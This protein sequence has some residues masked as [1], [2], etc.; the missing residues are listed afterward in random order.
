MSQSNNN[1][2]VTENKNEPTI[3]DVIAILG[4]FPVK[5]DF[6]EFKQ[7]L[8]SWNEENKR[9][10]QEVEKQ[11]GSLTATSIDNTDR[12]SEL[13][14]T[15]QVLQQ[16]KLRNNV[17]ISG[18]PPDKD[19]NAMHAVHKI[20][21]TLNVDVS[22]DKFT[23]FPSANN[24]LIIV[25][26][27]H[28]TTKQQ[29]INKIRVKKSLIVEEVFGPTA[30]SNSQ[31]YIND[32]LTK[33][34]SELFLMTRTAKKENKLA[35]ASSIGGKIRVRKSPD[36][37]PVT[38]TN[39]TQ[40]IELIEMDASG[41]AQQFNNDGSSSSQSNHDS[42]RKEKEKAGEKK[43][44]RPKSNSTGPRSLS[45]GGSSTGQ[46]KKPRTRKPKDKVE[47]ASQPSAES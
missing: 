3:A 21:N 1:N 34:F 4:N 24:K 38:I 7:A 18:V 2:A 19:L 30:K 46:S 36:S 39:K 11:V 42:R 23:A 43:R 13:E 8:V 5:S 32:H 9:K 29:L 27:Q 10:I 44:G 15:I 6:M 22:S 31:I 20:A 37:Y 45:Q 33:Y 35:T 16:E 14:G 40:L 26:F 25:S 17:C 47:A 41:D 12:I 28:G